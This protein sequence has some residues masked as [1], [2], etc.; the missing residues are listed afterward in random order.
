MNNR[1]LL[2]L[3]THLSEDESN[4]LTAWIIEQLTDLGLDH[5]EHCLCMRPHSHSAD[6]DCGADDLQDKILRILA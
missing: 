1:K 2:K 3:A 6:C 4:A 5:N